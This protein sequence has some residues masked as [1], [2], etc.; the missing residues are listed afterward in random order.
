MFKP[1]FEST[2][3][4]IDMPLAFHSL[5]SIA[6]VA[7]LVIVRQGGLVPLSA[8]QRLTTAICDITQ[9]ELLVEQQVQ[10]WDRKERTAQTVS[11]L[12]QAADAV[13]GVQESHA[14]EWLNE[15]YQ[16]TISER[17]GND[18]SDS[19]G[20]Q[21]ELSRQVLESV[22]RHDPAWAKSL[23]RDY[24]PTEGLGAAG[25]NERASTTPLSRARFVI[26][27]ALSILEDNKTFAISLFR[28]TFTLPASGDLNFF[29]YKLA[30]LD[31]QRAD[32]LYR[33]A[34]ANYSHSPATDFLYFSAYP[35]ALQRFV[36]FNAQTAFF[37]VPSIVTSNPELE[38]L[39]L[40]ELLARAAELLPPAQAPVERAAGDGV[41]FYL[42]LRSLQNLIARDL[43][44][45]HTK[46]VE[47]IAALRLALTFQDV[48]KADD[49]L[50]MRTKG[51][52][53]FV[54]LMEQLERETDQ[55]KRDQMFAQAAQLVD[56][57]G[58]I[59]ALMS[60]IEKSAT[61]LVR[62][63]LI[64]WLYF[65]RVLV[66]LSEGRFDEAQSR[67][68]SIR[69]MEFQAYLALEIA[70]RSVNELHDVSRTKEILEGVVKRSAKAP[71]GVL[72][73]RVLL[74]ICEFYASVD[75]LRAM[76]LLRDAVEV[77]NGL[78]SPNL[79]SETI[80]RE[81]KGRNFTAYVTYRISGLSVKNV[82]R[83]AAG[84]DFV[85]SILTARKLADPYLRASSII[86]VAERC[87]RSGKP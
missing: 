51:P 30:A 22:A 54:R 78:N 15:A 28:S 76:E 40:E 4:S 87:L 2:A 23:L 38:R 82:F 66:A 34:F 5:R 13:W 21:T 68:G 31:R 79:D 6:I 10:E 62:E 44:S 43:P 18:S 45:Y 49:Y 75:A 48:Q 26:D 64:D 19:S 42:T 65:K 41:L 32:E 56:T 53:S 58:K 69:K 35:F 80:V 70:K 81:V 59:D 67:V 55:D 3:G 71:K 74:G 20:G 9:G 46:V 63:E 7:I 73:V 83:Q 8:P 16:L 85:G 17:R 36:G 86:A 12:V 52:D 24:D 84:L 50:Q 77:M 33:E 61:L 39:F 29:L 37:D 25:S 1:L 27:L 14:R 60:M 72:K 47:A 57:D 11:L